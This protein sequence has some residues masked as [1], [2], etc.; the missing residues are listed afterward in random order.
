MYL[1]HK[2]GFLCKTF[3]Y[4]QLFPF[5]IV[6]FYNDL[7]KRGFI[8]QIQIQFHHNYGSHTPTSYSF[9]LF[10]VLDPYR[11]P[12]SSQNSKALRSVGLDDLDLGVTRLLSSSDPIPSL[13][14]VCSISWQLL[15]GFTP[16]SVEIFS[17]H[18]PFSCWNQ[19]LPKWCTSLDI[20]LAVSKAESSFPIW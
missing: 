1:L 7:L 18:M 16:F 15:H 3:L 13:D 6:I 20:W 11:P 8:H 9:L 14:I 17:M 2:K 4:N 5:F 10:G 19:R 12:Y